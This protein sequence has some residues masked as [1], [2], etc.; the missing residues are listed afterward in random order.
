MAKRIERARKAYAKQ[1]RAKLK[2]EYLSNEN[3]KEIFAR[4]SQSLDDFIDNDD[5]IKML[6]GSGKD[7]C[8]YFAD[9][10]R[11]S[12]MAKTP[13]E[14][15]KLDTVAKQVDYYRD[16]EFAAKI[17]KDEQVKALYNGILDLLDRYFA[18]VAESLL[19]LKY[20]NDYE[21]FRNKFV[22]DDEKKA[23]AANEKRKQTR[24]KNKANAAK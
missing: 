23:K 5:E 4:N 12:S 3:L 6:S 20:G 17:E 8:F 15:S 11:R 2:A 24:A 1:I 16:T 9:K 22:A 10:N 21:N 19:V 18:T 7:I 14:V 13:E